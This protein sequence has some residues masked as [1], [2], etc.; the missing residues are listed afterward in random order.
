M[1]PNCYWTERSLVPLS[2]TLMASRLTARPKLHP[3]TRTYATHIVE[4]V[5]L[6]S[7]TTSDYNNVFDLALD[8]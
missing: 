7:A 1:M 5:A 2:L 6:N 3:V 8:Y 4:L